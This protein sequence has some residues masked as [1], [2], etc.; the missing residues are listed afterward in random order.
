MSYKYQ[1]TR[2]WFLANYL[3]VFGLI[4]PKWPYQTGSCLFQS[5]EMIFKVKVGAFFRFLHNYHVEP[6]L[7]QQS[8]LCLGKTYYWWIFLWSR[9]RWRLLCSIRG[10]WFDL[11]I[12]QHFSSCTIKQIF[13][14]IP[15]HLFNSV[16]FF[17][18][19]CSLDYFS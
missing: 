5:S 18:L 6:Q 19:S 15:S 1:T 8:C 11:E 10:F 9:P 12:L 13:L 7:K 14:M 2:F 17:I 4:G 3:A 16:E